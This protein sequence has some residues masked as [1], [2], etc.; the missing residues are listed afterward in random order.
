ML[1]MKG[2]L[3]LYVGWEAYT[4]EPRVVSKT[5]FKELADP[6]RV[7]TG[8]RI[9]VG[10]KAVQVGRYRVNTEGDMSALKQLGGRELP[11][12]DP[13]VIGAW[14]GPGTPEPPPTA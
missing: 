13:T 9:R 1:R 8:V 10:S 7:G 2:A 4:D 3:G 12:F 14:R 11:E 5:W 6:W